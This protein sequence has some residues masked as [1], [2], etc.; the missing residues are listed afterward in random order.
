MTRLLR[1][2]EVMKRLGVRRTKFAEMVANGELPPA[3]VVSGSV[4]CWREDSIEEF[5]SSL[6]FASSNSDT[7]QPSKEKSNAHH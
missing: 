3:V 2:E 1:R 5:I 6:P 4:R 7:P